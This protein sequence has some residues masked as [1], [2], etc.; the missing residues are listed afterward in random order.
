M[1]SKA[2]DFVE[3]ATP[4]KLK[5]IARA[6]MLTRQYCLSEYS[7]RKKRMEILTQLF[8]AIG[9]NVSIDTPFHCNLGINISIGSNVIIG[10]N[11]TFIDDSPILI[12]DNVLIAPNVQIYTA[13][14]P[15][16]ASERLIEDWEGKNSTFFRTF[17]KPVVV[18]DNVWI[19][20]GVIIL[21][22]VTIG[23]NSVI[24]AG[25]VV[26]RSVPGNS[27]AFGN[28]CKVVKEL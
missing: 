10:V 25:S 16:A 20:G 13:S 24:G 2:A 9:D 14:H 4:E 28:P 11:C 19:G 7:D 23:K 22:G 6:R 5:Q 26:T 12:G 27:L 1:K 17:A 21:P 18:E 3:T 15:S 8:R